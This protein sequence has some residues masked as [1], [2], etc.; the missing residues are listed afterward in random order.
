[1]HGM[2]ATTDLLGF[3]RNELV[4]RNVNQVSSCSLG[5][6]LECG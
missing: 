3:A 2:Q 4:G 6:C 1:M 5:Q